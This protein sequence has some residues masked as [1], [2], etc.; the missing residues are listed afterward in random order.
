MSETSVPALPERKRGRL[1]LWVIIAV[2][3]AAAVAA[4]AIFLPTLF[5]SADPSDEAAPAAELTVV[6]LGTTDG[7]QGHWR[8]LKELLI[9]EGIDLQL[10][11]YAEYPLPNPALAAGDDDVNAFQHLDYL[12]NHNLATGD[13]LQPIASTLIVPLPL[14]SEKHT[15]LD[16]FEQGAKVAIP[17]DPSNQAR[18][19]FVLEAAGLIV[20]AE[21][22]SVPTPAHIDT[23]RS[24]VTVTAIKASGTAAALKDHDGAIIN[25]NFAKDHGLSP[26]DIIFAVPVDNIANDPGSW[27]YINIIAARPGDIDKPEYLKVAELYH[28]PSVLAVLVEESG[29]SAVPVNE[30]P[31]KVRGWLADI[32]AQKRASNG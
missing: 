23:T 17:D 21:D 27:P 20:F 19:L 1:G 15:S 9:A 24:K 12:S 13:D 3:A 6:K 32:E 16:T 7:S 10:S 18:A 2:V 29:G 14:Y 25:N 22:V 26:S 5:A 28:H 30:H 31:E 11:E 4:A 8:V